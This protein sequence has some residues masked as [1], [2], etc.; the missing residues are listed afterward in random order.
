MREEKAKPKGRLQLQ[1]MTRMKWHDV[2]SFACK[3]QVLYATAARPVT[4]L[5]KRLE[6]V[7]NRLYYQNASI[8]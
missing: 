6:S 5:Q 7:H 8:E 2:Q 3:S 4:H 1:D